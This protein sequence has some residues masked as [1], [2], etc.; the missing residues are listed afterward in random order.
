MSLYVSVLMYVFCMQAY[1][2]GNIHLYILASIHFLTLF[3]SLNSKLY[4]AMSLILLK[5]LFRGCTIIYMPLRVT[6]NLYFV[7]YDGRFRFPGFCY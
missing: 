6:H 2:T 3:I 4:F 7:C 5:N 1:I